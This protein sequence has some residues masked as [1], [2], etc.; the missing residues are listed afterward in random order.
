MMKA[1]SGIG[2]DDVARAAGMSRRD[3]EKK[4]AREIG[5]TPLEEI[6]EIRLRRVRELRTSWCLATLSTIPSLQC[7]W[8]NTPAGNV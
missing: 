7:D 2:V 5:R 8:S 4:F 3:L 6:Q 1:C